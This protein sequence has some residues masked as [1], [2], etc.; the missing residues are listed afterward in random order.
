MSDPRKPLAEEAVDEVEVEN[1]HEDAGADE[2]S[3]GG[4]DAGDDDAGDDEP[5]D[6]IEDI[7]DADVEAD[8][9]GHEAAVADGRRGGEEGKP[10]TRGQRRFQAL[11]ERTRAAEER[12]AAIERELAQIRAERSDRQT[13]QQ[14]EE[15][16]ERLRLMDPAERA[17]YRAQKLEEKFGQELGRLQFQQADATDRTKFDGF[18]SRRP[19]FEKFNDEVERELGAL[20]RSGLNVPRETVLWTIIGRNAVQK[21]PAAKTRA[22]KRGAENIERQRA[23]PAA[24]GGDVQRGNARSG[25]ESQKRKE[26]LGNMQI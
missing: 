6:G 3:F 26:R 1:T 20:R 7:G 25:S 17:E 11:N 10:L 15:E 2:Q 19:E 22:A 23:R 5:T 16:A 4:A 8:D 14:R 21:A 13:T 9:D 18:L 24:A 12:A